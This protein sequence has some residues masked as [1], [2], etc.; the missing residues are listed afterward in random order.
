VVWLVWVRRWRRG[1]VTVCWAWRRGLVGV[2]RA[3]P[4]CCSVSL[5]LN[6]GFGILS[7]VVHTIL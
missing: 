1:L 6:L 5:R 2:A 3:V 7:G 4:A